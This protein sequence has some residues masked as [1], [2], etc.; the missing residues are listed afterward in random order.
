[1]LGQ[2]TSSRNEK[3]LEKIKIG[4]KSSKSQALLHSRVSDTYNMMIDSSRE[5]KV[6]SPNPLKLNI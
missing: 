3:K 1:M 5:S 2:I 4:G 6:S